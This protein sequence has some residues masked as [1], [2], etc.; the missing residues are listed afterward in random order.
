MLEQLIE[1]FDDGVPSRMQ[2]MREAADAGDGKGLASAAHYV[3]GSSSA[4]GM[5][6]ATRLCRTLEAR[7]G[8]CD[9]DGVMDRERVRETLGQLDTVLSQS[10]LAFQQKIRELDELQSAAH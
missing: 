6:R 3:A 10:R 2:A 9:V 7:E 1:A 5:A 4:L 8:W